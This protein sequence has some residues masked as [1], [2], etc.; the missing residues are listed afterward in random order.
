[1]TVVSL[2]KKVKATKQNSDIKYDDCGINI[3]GEYLT[4]SKNRKLKF[5]YKERVY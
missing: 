4:V 3:N 1:M 5:C 2:K